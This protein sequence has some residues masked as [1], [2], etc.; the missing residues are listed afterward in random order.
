MIGPEDIEAFQYYSADEQGDPRDRSP[1]DMV[2]E[3][4]KTA[5]LDLDVDINSTF[6]VMVEDLLAFRLKLIDAEHDELAQ[7]IWKRGMIDRDWVDP[8]KI[9]KELADLVY[10]CYGL[11]AT[12]GFDLDEAF[13][14][15]H[16]NNMGRMYQPDGTI[17]RRADG[18]IL[19][20]KDYPPVDLGDLT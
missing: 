11:A 20:N 1:L 14:R 3:Y 19:K 13:R 2:R 10:V 4:H 9:L 17:K 15:V 18:K 12:F 7:E 16:E 8:E 6:P 5:K